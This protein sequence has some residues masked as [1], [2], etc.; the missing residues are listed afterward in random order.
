M[1]KKLNSEQSQVAIDEN[2]TC[3]TGELSKTF[4]VSHHMTIY[5]DMKDLVGK[6]SKIGKCFS[7][8]LS[9]VNKQHHVTC[10]VSLRSCE[11]HTSNHN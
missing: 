7:H 10:C 6:V 5:R 9:E 3:T 1:L 4:N 8:D 11:L 2:P